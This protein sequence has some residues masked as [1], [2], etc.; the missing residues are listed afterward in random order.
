V[1]IKYLCTGYDVY[2]TKEPNVFE[3]MALVHSRIRRVVF[4]HSSE[5]GGL[6]GGGP[7][8]SIHSLPATNHRYRAFKLIE[9]R[10]SDI[11]LKFIKIINRQKA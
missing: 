7:E 9:D 6:G 3:A 11:Y 5:D 10:S 4:C 1:I 2:L 8:T